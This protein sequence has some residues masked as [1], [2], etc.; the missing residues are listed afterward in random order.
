MLLNRFTIRTLLVLLLTYALL[1]AGLA[2]L[3]GC[4]SL[5]AVLDIIGKPPAAGGPAAATRPEAGARS[6]EVALALALNRLPASARA[7][8]PFLPALPPA[9]PLASLSLPLPPAPLPVNPTAR[10]VRRY[11]RG[12]R[13][14]VAA[15]KALQPAVP[16]KLK[17]SAVYAG[18]GATV[19][20]ATG[21]GAAV[22][23]SGALAIAAREAQ[24]VIAQLGD[25]NRATL[26]EDERPA[27]P[28]W[29]LLLAGLVLGYGLRQH[30]HNRS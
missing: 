25:G 24:E 5:R 26:P 14:Y 7:G 11:R 19:A 13:A 18:P 12:M 28:T 9:P 4:S 21:K 22:A 17:G 23:D 1:A 27:F 30:F 20:A 10:Q 2:L 6:S 8:R 15:L 3:S 29:L 16:R